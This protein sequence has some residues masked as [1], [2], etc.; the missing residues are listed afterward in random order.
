[1]EIVW[2]EIPEPLGSEELFKKIEKYRAERGV[3]VQV[4]DPS[5][6]LSDE[7]LQWALTKAKEC[8]EHGVNLADSLEIEVLLWAAGERQIKDALVKMGLSDLSKDAVILMEKGSDHFLGH[9]GW[10]AKKEDIVPSKEKLSK[11]GITKAEIDSVH[12]PYELI[13]EKMATSRL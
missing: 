3:F 12:D 1:M 2:A 4:F 6:V 7:H 13:F 10:T 8:F 11:L 5:V 9:M